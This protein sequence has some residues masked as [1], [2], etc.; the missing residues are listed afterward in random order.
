MPLLT[1]MIQIYL[2]LHTAAGKP[3]VLLLFNA[4]PLAISWAVSSPGVH[5]IVE[6]FFPA[7]ATGEALRQMFT[8]ARGANPGGRLTATWPVSMDQVG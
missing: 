1:K 8:N 4:E 2:S 7:Q 5:A 6:C 3:L